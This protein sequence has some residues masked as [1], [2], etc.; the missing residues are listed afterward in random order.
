MCVR[1]E[2]NI[3][4]SRVQEK[5]IRGGSKLFQFSISVSLQLKSTAATSNSRKVFS[6]GRRAKLFDAIWGLAVPGITMQLVDTLVIIYDTH[7]HYP[8]DGE[9]RFPLVGSE[10]FWS[11]NLC[12]NNRPMHF[13]RCSTTRGDADVSVSP[14]SHLTWINI[15]HSMN[16]MQKPPRRPRWRSLPVQVG[17]R[18]QC[19][20]ELLLLKY[21]QAPGNTVPEAGMR[22]DKGNL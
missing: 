2:L 6:G 10:R 1:R 9:Q 3:S 16:A 18:L 14:G 11:S 5:K 13:L 22:I 20:M 15:C 4:D 8:G 7:A 17:E 21:L 12:Q 19:K